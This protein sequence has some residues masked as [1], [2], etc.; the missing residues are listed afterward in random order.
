MKLD[1]LE[2]DTIEKLKSLRVV[3]LIDE[4]HRSNSGSQNENLTSTFDEI[5]TSFDKKEEKTDVQHK[6]NLIIGFTATPSDTTLARFGEFNRYAQGERLWKPFDSYTMREAIEDGYIL[7]PLNGIVSVSAKMYFELPD[8]ELEGFRTNDEDVQFKISKKAIYE[9]LE[10]IDAIAKH[11]V[12]NLVQVVYKQIRGTAKAMLA[13]TSIKSAQMYKEKIEEH[14]KTIVEDKKYARF[15]DA[16]IFVVYSSSQYELNA[17][18]LNEGLN[19]AKVLQNF[20]ESK[21]GIIIV[22]DKLQTGFDE[23]KLHTLFLDK[24][25]KGISAIQTISR[26]NRTTKHKTDCKIV[27]FSYKNVNSSNIKEAFEHFSDVVVSDFDPL[28]ELNKLR[29]IYNELKKINIYKEYFSFFIKLCNDKKADPNKFMDLENSFEK[30]I[31]SNPDKAKE[32]K[33]KINKYFHILGLVEY[34]IDFDKKYTEDCFLEFFR[35]YSSIYN[36]LNKTDVSTDEVLIYFDNKIGIIQAPDDQEI[37]PP[38]P[39]SSGGDGSSGGKEHKYDILEI[40]EKRNEEEEDIGKLIE[41]FQL[42]IDE[43]FEL[44]K[45]HKDFNDLKAKIN[46]IGFDESEVYR[47]FNIIYRSILRKKKGL[48]WE[49]FK[50]NT[51]DIVDKI[52]DD[53]E[54]SL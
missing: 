40:I 53:F 26:V 41:D 45:S 32:L 1:I 29:T 18:N 5:Q 9:N 6:K 39:P 28:G 51:N 35:R 13:T 38:K 22:V 46:A 7:N 14:F 15:K 23:P 17:K 19:E 4:I 3:F 34:I 52:C 36:T 24:E 2:S 49:F 25:V 43:F 37:K 27:D 31:H 33:K 8:D 54:K 12:Q 30:F 16:P 44:V 20:Q 50:K 42:L 11:I 47:V 21:N 10:R 48:E